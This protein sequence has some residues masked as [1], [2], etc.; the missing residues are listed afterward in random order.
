MT[1]IVYTAEQVSMINNIVDFAKETTYPSNVPAKAMKELKET[2]IE[3]VKHVTRERTEYGH[4]VEELTVCPGFCWIYKA[5]YSGDLHEV[6][7]GLIIDG[8]VGDTARVPE[9]YLQFIR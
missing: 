3:L 9:Q 6:A 7:S 1:A 8:N 4:R 2:S 5:G